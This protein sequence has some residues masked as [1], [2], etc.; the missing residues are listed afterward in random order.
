MAP[1]V[2]D[3][4]KN[5]CA[6]FSSQESP[7]IA[8]VRKEPEPYGKIDET[9]EIS[10]LYPSPLDALIG[11]VVADR[12]VIE[13]RIGDG[14][15]GVVYQAYQEPIH[16]PV[17]L[18]IL[19]PESESA[20]RS[21]QRFLIEARIISQ[22]RHPNTVKLYDFGTTGDGRFF[23]A[24]EYLGGGQL[25]DLMDGRRIDP[26]DALRLAEQIL[27]SLA[28]AHAMG[29]THR[30]LKPENVL[31]ERIQGDRILAKV[32]DFGVAKLVRPE[33]EPGN[34]LS[35]VLTVPGT[36]LGTPAYMSPEQAFARPTD[37]RSDLYSLGVILYEMLTGHLPFAN[38]DNTALYLAHLHNTPP[39]MHDLA[40]DAPL[41]PE[42]DELV[43]Q[44][45][46]KQPGDRP[47]CAE[48]VI[49]RIERI[50][51]RLDPSPIWNPEEGIRTTPTGERPAL[52][53][54][55]SIEFIPPPKP[56]WP[57][58]IMGIGVGALI[59]SLIHAIL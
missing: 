41:D 15:M 26:R 45:L 48:E 37:G 30:D 36:R 25:R 12:Y 33:A 13:K 49:A 18:K 21:V 54:N 46:A 27:H 59:A 44:L 20:D 17:A 40:P 23:I 6:E 50:R 43:E 24:M 2:V 11:S 47:S 34:S 58:F 16:R 57:F 31:L 1:S 29:I 28:E 42:L 39:K 56:I 55:S 35:P 14:G 52:R 7:E 10:G 4:T 5:R 32:V 53:E 3:L 22:L 19:L 9:S 38:D 51:I 8:R